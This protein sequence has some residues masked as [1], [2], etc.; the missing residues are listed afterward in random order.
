MSEKDKSDRVNRR[1]FLSSA[2]AASVAAA[3]LTGGS[4]ASAQDAAS[5]TSPQP[6]SEAEL[7]MEYDEPAGYSAEQI[8][9]YF[10]ERPGSDFM[11]DVIKSLDIEYI[12]TNP[13][14][15]FRG[16]HE[17]I[18]NYGGNRQPE[19]LTCPHEEQAVAMG[20]G[21]AKVAGKPLAM[22]AHGTVGFQHASMAVYNAWC[23]RVP[24]VILG[25]NHYDAT[26]RRA[27]VEWAH[28]AQDAATVVKDYIKWDDTPHSLAHF[29]ESM[30][31]A[32]KIAMT[33]PMGPV[34]IMID[35]HLQE[36]DIGDKT[37]SIPRMSPTQAPVGDTQAVE[38]AARWLV[39][40]EAPV[41][42]AD[43]AVHS[44]SG[45][46]QL[47]ALAEALEAP[48]VNLR[49]RL[50]FPNTHPLW[51]SGGELARAD[52]ILGLEVNDPWSLVNRLP[53]RAHRV[54]QRR[55]RA[56]A[57]VITIGVQDLFMKSNY[58]DFQRYFAADLS[59]AGDAQ[60]TLPA[61]TE[62]VQRL[63]SRSRRRQNSDRRKR[64]E[65]SH[66]KRRAAS[67]DAARYAWEASPVSTARIY[68]ELWQLVKDRDWAMVSEDRQQSQWA[69]RL[70][71]LEKTYQFIG[72]SGGAGVGYGA[73]AAVGAALAHRAEGRLPINIQRDGD[74]MYVPGT[75]W[76]AA[77]HGIPL[78]TITHN[79][80]GYHQEFM[81]LQRMA[82]RRRRGL[83]GSSHIGNTLTDPEPNLAKIAAGMG[84]WSTGP[85]TDPNDVAPAIRRALD[86]IDNNEPA[87]IDVVCQPR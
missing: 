57:R 87:F 65:E 14:S 21:Y 30:M 52:V 49:G 38:E 9:D 68:M 74:M 53:D 22:L 5:G 12:T 46:D 39:E 42:A 69:R 7:A 17:S 28:S 56:D 51:Q 45:M 80:R 27:G 62:A 54:A 33:P 6:P 43:R 81:H 18:V 23:D 60:A 37:F 64:W 13:G 11:V 70:W 59:I 58:Q 71:P 41:I 8:D 2:A 55:A 25:G 72:G 77:H 24:I 86:V 36:A 44:Q 29:A 26:E 4:R 16:I 31:R 84:C 35:G 48:V 19:L 75:F 15:S 73:P 66:A 50:N 34:V 63:M 3:A 78:L 83:E 85:I 1:E 40:A 61:L 82:S 10:V 76:T 32:Y 20:H 67:L 47:V 79:N